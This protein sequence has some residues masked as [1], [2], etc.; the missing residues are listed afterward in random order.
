VVG[1]PY[2]VSKEE[3]LAAFAKDNPELGL[4]VS[5][6]DPFTAVSKTNSDLFV[7]ITDVVKCRNK[8]QYRVLFSA[9]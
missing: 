5:A 1:L 9:S 6:N 3:A 8:E 7:S 4:T 2:S